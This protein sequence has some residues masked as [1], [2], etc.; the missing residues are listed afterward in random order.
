MSKKR[1][2]IFDKHG[3]FPRILIN[4]DMES[5]KS[6][7]K[8]RIVI[9][10]S[11]KKLKGIPPHLMILE[12]GVVRKANE[13]EA[14]VIQNNVKPV[15]L[16]E[17]KPSK[18]KPAIKVEKSEVIPMPVH[19]KNEGYKRELKKVKIQGLVAITLILG[20]MFRAEIQELALKLMEKLQ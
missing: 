19:I 14:K 12:D 1:V 2:L 13:K 11:M 9:N 3:R 16:Q 7:D 6:I 20:I 4:P 17:D 18:E 5:L 10:P 15:K 8:S